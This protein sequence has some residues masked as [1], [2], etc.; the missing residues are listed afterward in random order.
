VQRPTFADS[1]VS[2]SNFFSHSLVV[3]DLAVIFRGLSC[4]PDPTSEDSHVRFPTAFLA[5]LLRPFFLMQVPSFGFPL[6]TPRLNA[7]LLMLAGRLEVVRYLMRAT[8]VSFTP[9]ADFFPLPTSFPRLVVLLLM[10]LRPTSGVLV[11][12]SFNYFSFVDTLVL[13]FQINFPSSVG[14]HFCPT[15]ILFTQFLNPIVCQ[16]LRKRF[17][18]GFW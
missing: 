10:I 16:R 9:L 4:C 17:P 6:A 11:R 12:T 1:V 3:S 13:V 18:F 5:V 14:E 7:S 2:V 15:E 8:F